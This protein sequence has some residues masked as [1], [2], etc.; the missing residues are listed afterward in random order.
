MAWSAVMNQI[1]SLSDRARCQVSGKV[2]CRDRQTAK[3]LG[4]SF[5]SKTGQRMSVYKCDHC[6]SY[7]I[8]KKNGYKRVR[9]LTTIAIPGVAVVPAGTIGNLTDKRVVGGWSC[10]VELDDGTE[11]GCTAREIEILNS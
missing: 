1:V 7:H 10:Y 9:F 8:T 6:G 11:V 4:R 5:R 2:R 3:R